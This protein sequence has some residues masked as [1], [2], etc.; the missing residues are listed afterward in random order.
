MEVNFGIN[1]VSKAGQYITNQM[2]NWYYYNW[3]SGDF[4]VEMTVHSLDMMSWAMGDKMPVQATGTGGR[5]VRG[6]R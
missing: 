3:L 4:I 1:L 2:R 5:Q 6:R